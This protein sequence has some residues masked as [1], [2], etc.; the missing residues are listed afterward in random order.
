MRHL[1]AAW[2]EWESRLWAFA[3]GC[4]GGVAVLPVVFGL[5]RVIIVSNFSVLLGFPVLVILTEKTG[6]QRASWS[7]SIGAS[8]FLTSSSTQSGIRQ[9]KRK[10]RELISMSF[11]G[12]QFP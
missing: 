6:F 12:S 10:P 1:T 4:S 2:Q 8:G 7:V 11:L 9:A 5:G 3:G